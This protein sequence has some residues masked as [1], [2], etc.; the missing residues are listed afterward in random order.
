[1][2][3]KNNRVQKGS[4]LI[5]SLVF[6]S[7][8]VVIIGGLVS[9]AGVNIKASRLAV[10]REQALQIAES[11]I[12]YYR[13]H[14]AHAPADY[15]DGTGTSTPSVHQFY[16]KD[17]NVIG[18]FTLEITPPASGFTIVTIKSTGRIVDDPSIS[19]AVTAR[20][21]IPSL[22]KFAVVSNDNMRF[23][24]GTEVF[25]PIHSNGG[26]RFDGLA[27]NVISSSRDTYDDP[28]HNG[29][30][31]FGVHTHV[32]APPGSGVNDTFR[33]AEAPNS[34]V[35]SRPDVF[36]SGRQ[37]PLPAVDFTGLT[38][39]LASIKANAQASGR[40]FSASGYQGY[41]VVFKTNDTFDL[42]RVTALQ[43]VGGSCSNDANQTG[44]GSWSIRTS[45][46]GG[47]TLLGN[48]AIPANGLIFLED[49]VWVDGQISGARVT[50][51]AGRFPDNPATRPSITINANLLYTTYDGNDV[52]SLI[53]QGNVNVGQYSADTLRIDAALVAQNGR[54][55]RYYY[56]SD[57]SNYN[58]T[59][60]TLY[61]MIATNIRYG[62]AY[63]DG[64]GYDARNII[65]DANLLYGPP[66]SFP[67]TSDQYQIISWEE[68]R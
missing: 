16:D 12:D 11:G 66:P 45:G 7:I 39:D 9:W 28:D 27:H 46:G 13:W 33:A 23:G 37:F 43:S 64:T 42:Y 22:A 48:Y 62:F 61:G 51:A 17:G 63:T 57:C 14:L 4:I 41:R 55:G 50:L 38:T 24:E 36:E 54:V 25:G 2:I 67:L 19:R 10:Y 60:L 1:M 52:I 44:W 29:A 8:A 21:A 65:Y 53:S 30:N 31:E 59:S 26:I 68:T 49:N 5:Q 56:A 35:A 6:G 34:A 40:Y 32:T 15:Q 20:F 3:K 58:R 18:S 47:Q